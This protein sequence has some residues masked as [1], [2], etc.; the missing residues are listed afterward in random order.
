M[1]LKLKG[2]VQIIADLFELKNSEIKNKALNMRS[3]MMPE[4]N[5]LLPVLDCLISCLMDKNKINHK[6]LEEEF[7]ERRIDNTLPNSH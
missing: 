6:M 2:K 7:C 3:G 5:Y 1:D 4:P